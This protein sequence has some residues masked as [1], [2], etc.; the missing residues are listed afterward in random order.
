MLI[1][2]AKHR[3][4]TIT[5]TCVHDDGTTTGIPTSAYFVEHDLIQYAVETALGYD[6]AFYGQLARGSRIEAHH[7][8]QLGGDILP[9]TTCAAQA[10]QIVGLVQLARRGAIDPADF[11]EALALVAQH[12]GAQTPA[13][14]VVEFDSIL[15]TVVQLVSIW[16]QLPAGDTLELKFPGT[17][18]VRGGHQR[19]TARYRIVR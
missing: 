14:S 19:T 6:D 9:G 15:L 7:Q 1:R 5:F 12:S 3:D 16:K 17:L 4:D 18:N 2:F 11:P 10:R 8:K 13:L